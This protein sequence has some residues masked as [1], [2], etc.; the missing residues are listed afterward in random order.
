[1][2]IANRIVF[3]LVG[4]STEASYEE[5]LQNRPDWQRYVALVRTMIDDE[6]FDARAEVARLREELADIAAMTDADDPESYR[7]DDREGCLDWVH[8]KAMRG[9]DA[10]GSAQ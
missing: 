1:M 10:A 6:L 5:R 4:P 7:C 8:D 9:Q 2:D 3:E